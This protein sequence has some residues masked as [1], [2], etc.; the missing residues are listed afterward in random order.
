[1]A[2]IARSG[3]AK[4]VVLVKAAP[5]TSSG[6]RETVCVAAVD[7]Y[8]S[9]HRI[10]PVNFQGLSVEQRFGRWDEIE[11]D[12][13]LPEVAKDRRSESK[14]ITMETL[15]VVGKLRESERERYL[16]S[17]IVPTLSAAY[18]S[19]RSL[20]LVRPIDPKFTY[21]PRTTEE[22]ERIRRGYDSINASPD[23][24]GTT[25]I[26]PR[27]PAAYQFSYRFKSADGEHDMAC[28]DWET[29]QTFLSW[30]AGYGEERAL[31]D[32]NGTFGEQYPSKGMV[33]AMGTHG[34]RNWQW[35]IIGVIKLNNITQPNLF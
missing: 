1:V 3:R 28:H 32:M 23:L 2:V 7:A 10:Y 8:G 12:W 24:F 6:Y 17:A 20:A 18:A 16:A 19:G 25:D 11:F 33:F 15:S 13:R 26:V 14:R 29:E 4:A 27:E 5:Q 21:R 30:R 9:W 35:M 31:R 22:V 34:Q